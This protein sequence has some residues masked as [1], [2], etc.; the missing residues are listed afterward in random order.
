MSSVIIKLNRQQY[1]NVMQIYGIDF[2]MQNLYQE[3][4][5]EH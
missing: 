2:F 4:Y 5:F 3:V 1:E